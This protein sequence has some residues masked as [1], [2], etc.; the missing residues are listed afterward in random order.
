MLAT[1]KAA[2]ENGRKLEAL[3]VQTWLDLLKAAKEK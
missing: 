1:V 3:M 2:L